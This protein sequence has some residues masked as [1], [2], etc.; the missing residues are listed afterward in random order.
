[1]SPFEQFS[2]V[3]STTCAADGKKQIKYGPFTQ[4]H[5]AWI[6]NF[7]AKAQNI[8]LYLH[9]KMPHYI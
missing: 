4:R 6:E 7:A 9:V 1:M 8:P 2:N 3:Y 5:I